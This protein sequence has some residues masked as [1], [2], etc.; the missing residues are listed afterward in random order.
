MDFVNTK[1]LGH[2]RREQDG[3][4]TRIL[5]VE[6][7]GV[8]QSESTPAQLTLREQPRH[9]LRLWRRSDSCAVDE[10]QN[11][12]LPYGKPSAFPSDQVALVRYIP[13]FASTQM[14]LLC[15]KSQFVLERFYFVSTPTDKLACQRRLF[16]AFHASARVV[17]NLV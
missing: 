9:Y 1:A 16:L 6:Q 11:K 14:V 7:S 13:L 8:R 17:I 10:C 4:N 12:R 15:S 2:G 5:E 3:F